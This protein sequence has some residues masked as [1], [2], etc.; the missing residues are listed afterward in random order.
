LQAAHGGTVAVLGHDVTDEA[1]WAAAV[2]AAR[3]A[4]GA[5][6]IVVNNAGVASTGEPQDPERVSL[7]QWRAVNAIN[8]EGVLLGCQAAIAAMKETGG[9]IVNISSLAALNPSPRM[10][11][12][13]ASKAAVRHLTRT[14]AQY[15]AEQGYPIRCNSVHPGWF[16]T[17][18]VRA[19]RTPEELEV[20]RRAIPMG[21]FG[22]PEE[23]AKAVL[24]L[25]SDEAAYVT[26]AKLV[27]DGGSA[28]R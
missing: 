27:I 1:Q 2:A 7:A 5:L 16:P 21:R 23:V 4:F 28:M 17:P 6:H 26:G 3:D 11:A 13:G 8:V 18:M 20:Q 19:S 25:A 24:Y 10:A 14:V 22:E 12:Y 15:C 9:A